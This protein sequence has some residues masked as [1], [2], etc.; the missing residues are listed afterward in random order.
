MSETPHACH[1]CGAQS[2]GRLGTLGLRAASV[3]SD[4]LPCDLPAVIWQ[5]SACGHLQKAPTPDERTAIDRIYAT[6][7]AHHLSGG[8]E[9]LVFPPGL[10]PRPRTYHCIEQCVPRLPATGRLLDVGT[11]NGAVLKSAQALL[12]GWSLYG[13]DVGDKFRAEIEGMPGVR[14]FWSGDF[15]AVPEGNFDLAVLWHTLEHVPDPASLLSAIA[16]KLAPGGRVLIQVPD[17]VRNPFDLAVVDHESHFGPSQLARTCARAGLRIAVDGRAWVHNCLTLLLEKGEAPA[18]ETEMLADVF[19]WIRTAMEAIDRE[20]GDRPFAIFGTGMAG[21]WMATQF[22]TPPVCFVDEDEA[23][24]GQTVAGAPIRTPAALEPGVPVVMSFLPG[25]AA[26][27]ASRLSAQYP[28]LAG[29][30][31]IIAPAPAMTAGR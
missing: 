26:A 22:A 4:S 30:R 15:T 29:T 17:V 14:G 21:L 8:R 11:G 13:F 7:Q 23:R 1:A 12:P 31:F 18:L 24:E 6:Y 5:C 16:A 27:I 19:P 2:V 28:A 25:T 3:T 10:P 20:V 9:Q